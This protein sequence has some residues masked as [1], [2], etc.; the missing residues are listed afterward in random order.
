V[1]HLR[2]APDNVIER[3]TSVLPIRLDGALAFDPWQC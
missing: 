1:T 3:K 2:V